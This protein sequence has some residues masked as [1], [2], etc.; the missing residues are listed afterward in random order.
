LGSAQPVLLF[1]S[2]VSMWSVNVLPKT[3]FE[4]GKGVF[5]VALFVIL[6]SE[7]W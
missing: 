3:S 6:T 1:Q 7:A 4:G 2:T 5:G